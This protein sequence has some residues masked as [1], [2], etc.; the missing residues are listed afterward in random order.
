VKENAMCSPE[1]MAIVRQRAAVS[2]RDVLRT[3]A[4]TGI[5]AVAAGSLL[6]GRSARA[7]QATPVAAGLPAGFTSVVDLSHVWGPT[8]PMYPGAQ[9]P[10]IQVIVT[11]AENGFFKNQLTLDEHTG[12]HMDAPAHFAEDGTTADQLPVE[13]FIAPLVVVDVSE[14]T[15]SD[16]DTQGTVDDLTAWESANGPIPPGAFVALYSGWEARL[17]DP[18]TYINQDDAGVQHYPGWHP[19][20]AAFLVNER[21]VVGAGVD[22]LS[23]DFGA[24]TDFGTHLTLLPAGKFGIENLANLANVPPA[25]ATVIFGGPKHEGASGG[26]TRV[27]AL[28]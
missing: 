5:A 1:I 18:A 27:L 15:A 10:D 8:F 19:D 9:Q 2:R 6:S 11:I 25:G 16:P 3:G 23:L 28:V 12:T 22:T 26:P 21:D 14:R 7:L 4:A 17:I 13:N 24:S 20:A